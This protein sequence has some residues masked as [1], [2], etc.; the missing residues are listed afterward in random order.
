MDGDGYIQ[1]KQRELHELLTST[2]QKANLLEKRIE[3]VDKTIEDYGQLIAILKKQEQFNNDLQKSNIKLMEQMTEEYHKKMNDVVDI[4][5]RK[6][7]KELD[8][9]LHLISNTISDAFKKV[10][11]DFRRMDGTI[12]S[13]N[14]FVY[15]L[16]YQLQKK[17]IL[18]REN[19]KEMRMLQMKLSKMSDDKL[20]AKER[21]E[22]KKFLQEVFGDFAN[23]DVEGG[24]YHAHE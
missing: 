8:K 9:E 22:I 19:L 3:T 20:N 15:L 17:K 24:K 10:R 11:A 7:S 18:V 4:I 1:S 21:G 6:K 16:C 14:F 5:L 13:N 23:V 12:T 2:E